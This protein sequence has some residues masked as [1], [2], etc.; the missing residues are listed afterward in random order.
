MAKTWIYGATLNDSDEL[1]H[2]EVEAP[3][4]YLRV[5]LV[6]W[7]GLKKLTKVHLD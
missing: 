7:Q 1:D 5:E 2:E 6:L 3:I 4:L